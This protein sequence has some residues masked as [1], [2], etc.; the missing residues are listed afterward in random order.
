MPP[1]AI[2]L[3]LIQVIDFSLWISKERVDSLEIEEK[4]TWLL[5][6]K[7]LFRQKWWRVPWIVRSGYSARNGGGYHELWEVVI[8]LELVEGTMIW[9]NW[10]FRW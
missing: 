2:E 4:T 8:P 5:W 3:S 6:D 7:W 10:L 9:E 1:S